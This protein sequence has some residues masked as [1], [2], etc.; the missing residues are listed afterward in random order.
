MRSVY[1]GIWYLTALTPDSERCKQMYA[2]GILAFDIE[3]TRVDDDNA[4][5]Y[6]W[7]CGLWVENEY[8]ITYGRTWGEWTRLQDAINKHLGGIKIVCMVHNLSY[9]FQFLAGLYDMHDVFCLKA[10]K[11]LTASSGCIEY[12]CSYI[13]TNK[14]LNMFLRDMGV[15]HEKKSGF[16]YNK[17]RYPWTAMSED[18][19]EYCQN[20]VIGL[21]EATVKK[22]EKGTFTD[23]CGAE[24]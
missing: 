17:K 1:D 23:R 10:R 12:R 18:E 20:D 16:D 13:W 15:E 7:Q 19:I 22:L 6:I 14:A 21:L 3:T 5:M 9:E 8:F 4:V 2:N 11:I 24:P